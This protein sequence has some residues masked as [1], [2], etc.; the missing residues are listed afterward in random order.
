M[1]LRATLWALDEAVTEDARQVLVLIAL[2]DHADDNGRGCWPAV[3]TIAKRA[4]CSP[5]TVHRMLRELE[6]QG[7]V[8]R[9]DQ[10]KTA[11]IRPDR[12]PVVYD[13]VM[14]ARGDILTPRK[15]HEVSSG[16]ERG[17]MQSISG[18]TRMSHEPLLNRSL[19]RGVATCIVHLSRTPCSGCAADRLVEGE[20]IA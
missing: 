20:N 13:L 4:R 12:R 18:V 8:R 15:A 14:P 2:A 1:S 10:S 19:N 6:A 16:T 11:G 9:G 3:T 17:D 5:R 7:L